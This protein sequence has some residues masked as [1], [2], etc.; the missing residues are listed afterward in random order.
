MAR[1]RRNCGALPPD[2]P[3]P[4]VQL[5]PVELRAAWL[6]IRSSRQ[7]FVTLQEAQVDLGPLLERLLERVDFPI[8]AQLRERI[9]SMELAYERFMELERVLGNATVV[10][11]VRQHFPDP[12]V[13]VV[14]ISGRMDPAPKTPF[15]MPRLMRDVSPRRHED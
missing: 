1:A 4:E 6:K 3:V 10:L 7:V 15:R 12:P 13:S 9:E 5:S 14:R 8:R 11:T 2:E